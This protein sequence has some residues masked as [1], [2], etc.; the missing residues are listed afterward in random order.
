M[1][2]AIE[3]L[4]RFVAGQPQSFGA[5]MLLGSAYLAKGKPAKATETYRRLVVL[6]PKDPRGPYLVGVGLRAQ[7]KPAEAKNEFETA[8]TLAPAYLEPMQQLVA[9]AVARKNS[10]MPP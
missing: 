3:D 10:P 6:A 4:E 9:M 1:Q 5:Y 2:P 8:L 7:K